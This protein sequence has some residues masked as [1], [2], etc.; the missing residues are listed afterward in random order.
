MWRPL[1]YQR[2]VGAGLIGKG[3]ILTPEDP[4]RLR[5]TP[6]CTLVVGPAPGGLGVVGDAFACDIPRAQAGTDGKPA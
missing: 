6:R 2:V 3:M 4:D 5:A 1:E